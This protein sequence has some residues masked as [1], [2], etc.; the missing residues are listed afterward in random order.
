MRLPL[1]YKGVELK[2]EDELDLVVG[3]KLVVKPKSALE[4]QPVQHAELLSQLRLGAYK[5]GLLIN[6]NTVLLR[7]GIRR[8]V[9]SPGATGEAKF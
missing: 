3:K 8:V 1:S 7:N 9:L 6:F 2:S 4:I 5:L